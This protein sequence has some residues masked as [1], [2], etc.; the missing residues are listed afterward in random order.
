MSRSF[1]KAVARALPVLSFAALEIWGAG[2]C[3]VAAAPVDRI[4][5]ESAGALDG[6]DAVNAN[7]TTNI[8]IMN[9]DGTGRTPLSSLTA[10]GADSTGAHWSPDGKKI[11]FSSNRALDGS[12][13]ANV[14]ETSNVWIMNADGGDPK[15]LTRLTAPDTFTFASNWSPDGKKILFATF[16][17][18]DGSDAAIAAQN[19]WVMDADGSNQTPLTSQTADLVYSAIPAWSPHGGQILFSSTA[20]LDGSDALNGTGVGNLW[21]MNADGSDRRPLTNLTVGG[22]S[23][24]FFSSWSPDGA[25]IA[26]HSNRALDG[27]DALNDGFS[28]NLWL[29]N[30]DGTDLQPLT[31][32]TTAGSINGPSFSPDGSMIAFNSTYDLTGAD[33]PNG[34]YQYNLWVINADGSDLRPLTRLTV[35]DSLAAFR[36]WSPDST[37]ILFTSL[38]LLDGSDAV[39]PESLYNLWV[40]DV[41]GGTIEPLTEFTDPEA[42][43]FSGDWSPSF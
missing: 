27:S 10:E 33:A 25:K 11:L 21:I 28:E 17:A 36:D 18:L 41:A 13:A 43:N 16:R 7:E 3:G 2:G 40:A 22:F 15:P 42:D 23:T 39:F 35:E 29:M 12:D 4:V 5:F 1:R 8:W 38:G 14:N 9:A 24:H 30:A 26:F 20:A 32:Y 19:L 6:S 31:N 34:D 37:R